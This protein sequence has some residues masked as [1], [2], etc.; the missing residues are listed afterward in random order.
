M[1]PIC[2]REHPLRRHGWYPR[3][4]SEGG[5]DW[6][7]VEI[8][9]YFCPGCGK[10]VG[11]L[12]EFL[13]PYKR[14]TLREI[15]RVFY[16]YFVVGASLRS[17]YRGLLTAVVSTIAG[18]LKSWAYTCR[19]LIL[20]GFAAAGIIS[21]GEYFSG[22]DCRQWAFV[23]CE[24]YVFRE[25]LGCVTVN[26]GE[27]VISGDYTP[28]ELQRCREI[29]PRTQLRLQGLSPPLWPLRNI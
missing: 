10:T 6:Q 27:Y 11:I 19:H 1:C 25:S 22:G 12:P 14:Y 29:L 2:G 4:A 23:T 7:Q 8:L 3:W 16:L 5:I 21:P 17:I 9:R 13:T 24:R 26:C 18:W 28:C 20:R 15:S